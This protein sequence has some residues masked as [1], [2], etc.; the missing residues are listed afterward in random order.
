MIDVADKTNEMDAITQNEI[1]GR[2][3]KC[4]CKVNSGSLC[5][6]STSKTLLNYFNKPG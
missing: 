6:Y 4:F 5:Y 3:Q 2:A 1:E